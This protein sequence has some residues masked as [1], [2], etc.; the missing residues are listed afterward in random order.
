MFITKKQ[1][2]ENSLDDYRLYH[3]KHFIYNLT[4]PDRIPWKLEHA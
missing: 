4:A 3:K 2:D 1:S